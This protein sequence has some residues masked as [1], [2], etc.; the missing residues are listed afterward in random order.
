MDPITGAATFATLVSLVGQYRG[1]KKSADQAEFHDFLAWLVETQHAEIKSLIESN[2][3]TTVGIKAL[4]GVQYDKLAEKIDLLDRSLATY[5]SGFQ[6][7]SEI[8][9]AVWPNAG[10]SGQAISFLKQ[11]EQSGASKILEVPMYG[12]TNL[13]FMDAHENGAIEIEDRRFL[14]DDLRTLLEIGL[15]RHDLNSKNQNLYIYTR[16]AAEFVKSL[17]S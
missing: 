10:L 12:G 17:D 9:S 7:F 11:F 13:M 4:L 6:G 16:A 2:S 8:S 1:E 14:E 15:L 5:A 3:V